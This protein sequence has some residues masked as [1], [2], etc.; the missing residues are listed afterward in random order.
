MTPPKPVPGFL[1]LLTRPLPIPSVRPLLRRQPRKV[2]P[3]A[4]PRNEH[5]LPLQELDRSSGPV[6]EYRREC[7]LTHQRS[8]RRIRLSRIR[9][10]QEIRDSGAKPPGSPIPQYAH[11]RLH[12]Q[13]RTK[14]FTREG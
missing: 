14:R 9:G 10:E 13:S 8:A 1:P 4:P 5:H 3:R 11:R 12:S 7:D 6:A 2:P